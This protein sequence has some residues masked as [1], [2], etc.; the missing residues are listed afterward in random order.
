MW[1]SLVQSDVNLIPRF[2]TQLNKSVC[3]S[4]PLFP[5]LPKDLKIRSVHKVC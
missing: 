3:L 4:E 5:Y 1:F 2:A